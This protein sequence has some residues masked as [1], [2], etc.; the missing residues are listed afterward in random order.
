MERACSKEKKSNTLIHMR[1]AVPSALYIEIEFLEWLLKQELNAEDVSKM[2]MCVFEKLAKDF[3]I[4][5]K[6]KVDNDLLSE[7][8]YDF[9]KNS[10]ENFLEKLKRLISLDTFGRDTKKYESITE[11]F[12]RYS[13]PHIIK[14]FLSSSCT[15]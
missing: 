7:L 14:V 9:K 15:R 6:G 2:S 5:V 12:C 8:L 11:L 1:V 13:N 4:E 10:L 3:S